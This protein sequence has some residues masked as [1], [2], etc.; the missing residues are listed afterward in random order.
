MH[1]QQKKRDLADKHME[2]TLAKHCISIPVAQTIEH[3]ASNTK[4]ISLISNHN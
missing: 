2:Q 3:G 4:V 1:K